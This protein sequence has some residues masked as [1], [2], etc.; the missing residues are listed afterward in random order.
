MAALVATWPNGAIP[1]DV[2][3][4]VPA[5]IGTTAWLLP[6]P[7]ES[8]LRCVERAAARGITLQVVSAGDGFRSLGR[9]ITVFLERYEAR[10]TG[11]GPYNDVRYWDRY[12]T[13][14]KIRYVRMRGPAAAIPGTSNHGRGVTVDVAD[15]GG[16]TGATYR[17]LAPILT[18]EGWSNSE[19]ASIG[20]PWHW[21]YMRTAMPVSN[22]NTL[23][24][25]FIPTI[26]TG[27]LPDALTREAD[28]NTLLH[29]AAPN[30][31][32]YA[33]A[34]GFLRCRVLGGMVELESLIV[35]KQL[36]GV[37]LVRD[38]NGRVTG[39]A[40]DVELVDDLVWNTLLDLDRRAR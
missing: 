17:A 6:G 38:K 22:T 25:V 32:D 10:T 7:A 26:P 20:E 27:R 4:P 37:T 14:V 8:F 11:S 18:A 9:Q 36:P 39:V 12:G 21:N 16:F 29:R 3:N 2:L 24:G 34:G 40:G 23:P 5:K 13:G 19:G 35:A 30:S 1:L 31:Q 28:V 15:I 33:V